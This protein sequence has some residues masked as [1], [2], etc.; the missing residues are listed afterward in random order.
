MQIF[1]IYFFSMSSLLLAMIAGMHAIAK[2]RIIPWEYLSAFGIALFIYNWLDIISI[3]FETN[4]ILLLIKNL[5]FILAFLL[6]FE[7]SRRSFIKMGY[8]GQPY[9]WYAIP[10]FILLLGV[11]L[12]LAVFYSF[13]RIF[14]A[15]GITVL[16]AYQVFL[17]IK[18]NKRFRLMFLPLPFLVILFGFT[19]LLIAPNEAKQNLF[20]FSRAQYNQLFNIPIA[21]FQGIILFIVASG[22]W[23]FLYYIRLKNY[24]A[25]DRKNKLILGIVVLGSTLLV[26]FGGWLATN[27][28]SNQAIQSIEQENDAYMYFFNKVVLDEIHLAEHAV[29]GLSGSHWLHQVLLQD[30]KKN[31]QK[32]NSVLD[33]YTEALSAVAIYV[34]DVT[35]KVVVSS[36]RFRPESYLGKDFSS[37]RFFK[38]AVNDDKGQF[39][40]FNP[41]TNQRMLAVSVSIS[42]NNGQILGVLVMERSLE[43]LLQNNVMDKGHICLVSPE[44][45]I[46]TSDDTALVDRMLY[47]AS[48]LDKVRLKTNNP[49]GTIDWD[50]VLPNRIF[51]NQIITSNGKVYYV[52][53]KIVN[54]QGWE[55]VILGT[56]FQVKLYRFFAILLTLF[57]TAILF[58]FTIIYVLYHERTR[59]VRQSEIRLRKI[60][61]T[62][63]EAIFVVNPNDEHIIEFNKFM[64]KMLGMDEEQILNLDLETLFGEN[65]SSLREQI[66]DIR[67]H[68]IVLIKEH[69]FPTASGRFIDVEGTCTT[70]QWD[71]K[72]SI[73]F[74][75]HDI[76]EA[77][78]A[79]KELEENERKYR[80]VFDNASDAIILLYENKIFDCNVKAGDIFGA[81]PEELIGKVPDQFLPEFQ[82]TG[83]LSFDLYQEHM[84]LAIEGSAQRFECQYL[85]TDGIPFF[86]G[87]SLNKVE[88]KGKLMVQAIIRDITEQKRLQQRL[89]EARDKALDMAKAKSEF[90]A[91][92]SHEI[93]TPMNGVIGM[94]DLLSETELSAE[95][96]DYTKTAK[97]SADSLLAIINDILDFSKIEAGK[98]TIDS[99]DVEIHTL[100]GSVGDTLA[101]AA[102][103]KG[104]ELICEL[105]PRLPFLVQS[106]PVRL[107]QILIN[108]TNN[109]VKFTSTGEVVLS[110]A[111]EHE[112]ESTIWLRFSVRDTG[113]GI[114]KEKQKSIFGAFEQAD[115]STTRNFGGTGLGLAISKQL[116]EMMGGI[117]KLKSEPGIGS[118]FY[119]S[120][121]FEKDHI[122]FERRQ[123][124]V[125]DL[126]EKQVLIVDDNRTNQKVLLSMVK[127]LKMNGHAVSGGREALDYIKG[128]R[129]VDVILLDVNMP[130]MDGRKFILK[131]KK[132]FPHSS[133]KTIV[134]SSSGSVSDSKWFK[135]Q[136]CVDYINKP[137]KQKRLLEVLVSAFQI[138]PPTSNNKGRRITDIKDPKERFKNTKILLAEDNLI[139][140]KVATRIL[141]KL[142]VEIIIAG[143]G[144][145][146]IDML[147]TEKPDMILMDVQ[148]PK[149]DG[150]EATRTIR[151]EVE[152]GRKIPIIAMTAHAMKGDRD[153]CLAAGMNDYV[154]KPIKKDELISI[155]ARYKKGISQADQREKKDETG[156]DE[157][158]TTA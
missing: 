12:G 152:D 95:Q 148:M 79:T 1:A 62:A 91:N 16:I 83:R 157:E 137:I 59:S 100:I 110:S 60:L 96:M 124:F 158:Q 93:R 109:A 130:E 121:P 150:L 125:A 111:V 49:Y 54:G 18:R 84:N 90:L 52:N 140:Q 138:N 8:S 92:M 35:G 126:R 15:F 68:E 71:N 142:G 36:N 58:V 38:Q 7:F 135:E 11:A 143:D 45:L 144:V 69:V 146:A 120:L 80:N 119:F 151:R 74:F 76:S 82:P 106:D 122:V 64:K 73:I 40:F 17:N 53:R 56:I 132:E 31:I 104:L 51:G 108:L 131:L 149:M 114:P 22:A 39:I 87:I 43:K 28:Y 116:V 127:N 136:G 78:Q 154:S 89:Q 4:S 3:E 29:D 55:I 42:N 25:K 153:R 46:F 105:D 134:L 128:G 32:A 57:I 112:D 48:D 75:I 141:E 70:T 115:G 41:H 23:N 19:F 33:R 66:K 113:I 85:R 65:Y 139:N 103:D 6:L 97:I 88:V 145:E 117:L 14:L 123:P 10:V 107:R 20:L 147:K 155:I 21:Y 34:L 2:K 99:T 30:N 26:Q 37:L 118:E 101:K 5:V 129:S 94:L 72:E 50:P 13:I 156:S 9:V 102:H 24:S 67:H 98:L 27:I 86:A 44:G 77:K 47:P 81:S 61:D 63:P 133:I